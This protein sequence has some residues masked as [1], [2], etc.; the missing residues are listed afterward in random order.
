M[1]FRKG[2]GGFARLAVL[3]VQPLIYTSF[4]RKRPHV[5]KSVPMHP[6]ES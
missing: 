3:L 1:A 6:T 2:A 5:P 4:A